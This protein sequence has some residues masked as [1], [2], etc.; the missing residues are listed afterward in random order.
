M[1]IAPDSYW[2]RGSQKSACCLSDG[3]EYRQQLC[4]ECSPIIAF[5]AMRISDLP[6]E[7]QK[8]SFLQVTDHYS[9]GSSFFFTAASS[10]QF[11]Y[12]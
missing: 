7:R 5:A 10:Y 3:G 12:Y 2:Q 1:L 4:A 6:P 11:G 8:N 9:I